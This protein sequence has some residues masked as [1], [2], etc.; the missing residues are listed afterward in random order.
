M[1]A[2]IFSALQMPTKISYFDTPIDIRNTYQYFTEA[3][4][5]KL[6]SVGY[7]IPFTSLEDGVN[8]Y[9]NCYLSQNKYL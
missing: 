5:Q 7:Q 1:A 6:I 4:M 8:D 3:N 9:V 2:A